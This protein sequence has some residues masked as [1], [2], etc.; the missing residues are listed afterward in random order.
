MLTSSILTLALAATGLA[1]PQAAVTAPE[2]YK[3]VYMTSMVNT[4]FVVVPKAPVKAGTTLVVQQITNKVDQQWYLTDGK[5]RI[6]LAGTTLCM[7]AGAKSKKCPQYPRDRLPVVSF[8]EER[9]LTQRPRGYTGAWKDMASI[10]LQEC[11]DTADGQ[12]WNVMADGRIALDLSNPPRK[13]IHSLVPSLIH[14]LTKGA[15]TQ[16][17]SNASISSTCGPRRTTRSVCTPARVS[18]TPARRTRA[19]TGPSP[20]FRRLLRTL[21][22]QGAEGG[23]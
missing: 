14:Y 13:P 4:K 20:W 18:A 15:D 6:Q 2:G 1:L 23:A 3:T 10:A 17:Q 22:A 19:S 11:S 12:K 9:L 8:S 21:F 5:T 16:A 7:D